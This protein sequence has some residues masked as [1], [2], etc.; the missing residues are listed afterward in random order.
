M[1]TLTPRGYDREKLLD[2][3]DEHLDLSQCV[4]VKTTYPGGQIDFRYAIT[5][6]AEAGVP[7][8]RRLLGANPCPECAADRGGV[9]EIGN[10][11]MDHVGGYCDWQPLVTAPLNR[12][13]LMPP[14]EVDRLLEAEA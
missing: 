4:I 6:L 9:Y 5:L 1:T 3:M 10:V 12:D 2:Y 13:A 8:V 14:D 7:K 11:P